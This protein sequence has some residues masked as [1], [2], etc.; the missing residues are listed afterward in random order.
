M[1]STFRVAAIATLVSFCA[2]CTKTVH[3]PLDP[4]N[5]ISE[6][7]IDGMVAFHL[8]DTRTLVSNCVSVNEDAFVLRCVHQGSRMEDIEPMTIQRDEVESMELLDKK[9]RPLVIAAASGLFVFML[10]YAWSG[11]AGFGDI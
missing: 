11:K 8:R 7:H 4:D 6:K 1:K 2:A 3:V 5:A 10:F 9:Y